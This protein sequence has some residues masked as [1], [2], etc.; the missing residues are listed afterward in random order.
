[1]TEAITHFIDETSNRD[2]AA[3]AMWTNQIQTFSHDDV[4]KFL[5][6]WKICGKLTTVTTYTY[7]IVSAM[8]TFLQKMN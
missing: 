4:M 8:K 3:S 2:D 1:M 6:N 7:P 5:V